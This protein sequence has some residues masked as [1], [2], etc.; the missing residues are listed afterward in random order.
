MSRF[1]ITETQPFSSY[2]P[3]RSADQRKSAAPSA[4]PAQMLEHG[5][6]YAGT[7]NDAPAIARWHARKRARAK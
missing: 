6:Y 4:L 2:P 7:L 3:I 5:A 1:T